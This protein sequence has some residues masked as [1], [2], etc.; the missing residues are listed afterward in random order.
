[1][2]RPIQIVSLICKNIREQNISKDAYIN[3]ITFDFNDIFTLDES[4]EWIHKLIEIYSQSLG[5]RN[6]IIDYEFLNKIIEYIMINIDKQISLNSVADK[7]NVSTGH[8]SRL[9]KEG[10]GISFQIIS[11]I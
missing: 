6:S 5:K 4:L 8:L 1:M 11:L 9:F 2:T 10:A 7:F 3:D